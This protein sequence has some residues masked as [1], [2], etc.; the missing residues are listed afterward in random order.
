MLKINLKRLNYKFFHILLKKSFPPYAYP[1]ISEISCITEPLYEDQYN[2][3]THLCVGHH[4]LV[5][6]T[7][8]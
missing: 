7:M 5:V 2:T 1:N 6:D 4:G 3:I 8:G